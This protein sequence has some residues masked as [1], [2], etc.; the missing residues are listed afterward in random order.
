MYKFK[1]ISPRERRMGPETIHT[2]EEEQFLV[3]LIFT[4]AR[5]GFSII[6]LELLDS[7]QNLV[8]ELKRKKPLVSGNVGWYLGICKLLI[9]PS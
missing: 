2:M 6:K 1:R 8:T 9:F 3:Q 5:A 7:V 4:V